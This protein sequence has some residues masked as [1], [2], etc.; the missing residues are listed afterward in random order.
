MW[1]N[2]NQGKLK[3]HVGIH[4]SDKKSSKC[5][6]CKTSFSAK[7]R[8]KDHVDGVHLKKF[9][10][11]C[12]KCKKGLLRANRRT[13]S[14]FIKITKE[15]DCGKIKTI[16]NFS[17]FINITKELDCEKENHLKLKV[18]Q[19]VYLTLFLY[20]WSLAFCLFI[21]LFTI[22]NYLWNVFCE[23]NNQPPFRND[24]NV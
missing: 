8:L 22:D 13:S 16:R 17:L 23:K 1:K 20:N 14:L 6:F 24:K 9:R 21:L 7:Y 11:H 12:S 5:K 10:F 2:K 18:N 15:L 3:R 19:S 4:D